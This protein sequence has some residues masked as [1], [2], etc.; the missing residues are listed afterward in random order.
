MHSNSFSCN[1][2]NEKSNDGQLSK[3]FPTKQDKQ[4]LWIIVLCRKIKKNN[5]KKW[6]KGKSKYI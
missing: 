6:I 3:N 1:W 4:K 5:K 2:S